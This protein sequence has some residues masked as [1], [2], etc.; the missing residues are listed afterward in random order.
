[1][2]EKLVSRVIAWLN[3]RMWAYI[4]AA[5]AL[6]AAG[7]FLYGAGKDTVRK[8]FDAYR[9][10]QTEARLLADRA[11]R[12]EEQRRQTAVDKEATHAQ[13]QIAKLE[14]NSADARRAADSLHAAIGAAVRGTRK[15]SGAATASK[16]EPD[17]D[18]LDLLSGML[19]RHSQE[20]VEVGKY[21]DGVAAAGGACERIA[22]QLRAGGR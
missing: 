4:A 3:P 2:A 14:I 10:A 8:D 17:S 15:D 6:A 9:I 5:V 19:Y 16:G 18:P 11:Q 7:A 22:D 20:L 13:E 21:A 1:M 12:T